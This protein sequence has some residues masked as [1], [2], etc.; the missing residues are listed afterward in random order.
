MY[1]IKQWRL[2]QIRSLA[3]KERAT[4]CNKNSESQQ[5]KTCYRNSAQIADMKTPTWCARHVNV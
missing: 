5:K 1:Y 4:G 3:M 2:F